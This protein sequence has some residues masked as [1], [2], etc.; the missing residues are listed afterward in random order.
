MTKV[1]YNGNEIEIADDLE[2]GFMELDLITDDNEVNSELE[3][4]MEIDIDELEKTKNLELNDLNDTQDLTESIGNI[5][6]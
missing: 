1:M 6:E 2:K 5:N 4:T 3:K